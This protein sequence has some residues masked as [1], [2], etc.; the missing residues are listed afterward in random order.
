MKNF[1]SES[2]VSP[3]RQETEDQAKMSRYEKLAKYLKVKVDK[4]SSVES[5]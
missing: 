4:E 3:I 5:R 2:S 1:Q